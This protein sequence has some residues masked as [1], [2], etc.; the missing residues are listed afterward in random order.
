MS[1]ESIEI[2]SYQYCQ[3]STRE[4]LTKAIAVCAGSGGKK[5]YLYFN[6]GTQALPSASKN[7]DNYFLYYRYSDMP[8]IIDMLRNEKPIYLFYVPDGKDNTRLTTTSEPIGE[9]EQL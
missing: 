1:A 9:G 4:D 7:G 6:G 2:T 8:N 5:I 3:F